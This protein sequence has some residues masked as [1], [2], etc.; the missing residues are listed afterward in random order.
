MSRYSIKRI[1]PVTALAG[2]QGAS[3]LTAA[4]LE[5]RW[6]MHCP[7]CPGNGLTY[8]HTWQGAWAS[9][10]R[11]IRIHSAEGASRAPCT[12][13]AMERDENEASQFRN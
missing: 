4:A 3:I 13:L 1:D 12:A 8:A 10:K 9:V 7:R 6:A 11:H 5:L 2:G